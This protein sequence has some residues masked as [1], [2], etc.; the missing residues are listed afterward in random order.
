MGNLDS[1]TDELK[2]AVERL[3]CDVADLQA[4]LEAA[5]EDCR[6]TQEKSRKLREQLR[7][8]IGESPRPPANA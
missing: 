7:Q 6:R 4:Q 8:E 5:V 2:E 1:R 3:R